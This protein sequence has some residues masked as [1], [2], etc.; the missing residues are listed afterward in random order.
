MSDFNKPVIANTSINHVRSLAKLMDST[1][2]IPG[3]QIKFGLDALI[4]LIPG[5]GDLSTFV[6]SGYMVIIMA[7]NGASGFVLARMILNILLDAL[8]GAIPILGD[9]F[10]IAFKAN[11]KN[12]KLMD[13]YYSHGRHKGSAWKAII[14]ILF[15]V[16]L[17]VLGIGWLGYKLLMAIF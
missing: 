16:L 6:V 7:K 17:I 13:Q 4:G 1:F 11:N 3:T 15:I 12:I 2:K 5:V 10:D 8:V 9:L 14:P